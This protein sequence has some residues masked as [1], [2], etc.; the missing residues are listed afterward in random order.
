MLFSGIPTVDGRNPAP[1]NKPWND[2]ISVPTNNG[3]N[4][5]FN[6]VR[7]EF[8]HQYVEKLPFRFGCPSAL[9]CI[10]VPE[11]WWGFLRVPLSTNPKSGHLPFAWLMLEGE[12]TPIFFFYKQLS[13][14]PTQPQKAKMSKLFRND[15]HVSGFRFGPRGSKQMPSRLGIPQV[16]GRRRWH[17]LDGFAG[18]GVPPVTRRETWKPRLPNSRGSFFNKMENMVSLYSFNA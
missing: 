2:S 16:Y 4:Q 8:V 15:S 11:K 17:G 14:D 10:R 12:Q 13:T 5:A 1:P 9:F 7:T 3:F 6:M 18:C